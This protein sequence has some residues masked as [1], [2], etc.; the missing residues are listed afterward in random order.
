[1]ALP[2]FALTSDLREDNVYHDAVRKADAPCYHIPGGSNRE[3][4]CS[5]SCFDTKMELQEA[6]ELLARLAAGTRQGV[7]LTGG[8]AGDTAEHIEPPACRLKWSDVQHV[9]GLA[10]AED[11]RKFWDALSSGNVST[12]IAGR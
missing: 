2:N 12:S 7:E 4:S 11:S 3:S 8:G 5:G 1:M 10:E 9:R 6:T